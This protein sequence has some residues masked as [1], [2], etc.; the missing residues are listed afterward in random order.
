M[1]F[2]WDYKTKKKLY[3]I[4]E[5]KLFNLDEDFFFSSNKVR[6]SIDPKKIK[7]YYEKAA[8]Y[9]DDLGCI[10]IVK[11]KISGWELEDSEEAKNPKLP[12][13]SVNDSRYVHIKNPLC[14]L[15]DSSVERL[16]RIPKEIA[17]KFIILGMP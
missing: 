13:K 3:K 15:K 16:V 9:L 7:K 1:A 14:F 11:V 12:W 6:Y 8:K 10:R 4:V 5:Q 17:E 2:V